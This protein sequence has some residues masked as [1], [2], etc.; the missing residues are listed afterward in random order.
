MRTRGGAIGTS[1]AV[2]Y[3]SM[4]RGRR[5]QTGYRTGSGLVFF[6]LSKYHKV[7]EFDEAMDLL[8]ENS[9]AT[10]ASISEQQSNTILNMEPSYE[11]HEPGEEEEESDK[12]KLLSFQKKQSSFWTF[13]Y[14]QA[15]FD[16]DTYQVLDRIKGSLLPLPGK[17]FVWHHLRNNPDMYGPFWICATL[18][19]T[20]AF[21]GNL[22]NFL[23][24]KSSPSFHKGED[25]TWKCHFQC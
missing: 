20:L 10:T 23:E 15:L 11:E 21:S 4:L 16:V 6:F 14:Y 12:T 17:N 1:V 25:L 18:V 5:Q 2:Y 3:N 9:N 7:G 19:F 24:K 13:E 22:S 8:A